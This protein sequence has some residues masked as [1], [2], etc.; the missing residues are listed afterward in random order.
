MSRLIR[1]NWF[2]NKK[3]ISN[4]FNVIY[5]IICQTDTCQIP[6]IGTTKRMMKSHLADQC[7]YVRNL[8]E[9]TA[10]GSH[11]NSPGH[12]LL[13]RRIIALEQ[14]KTKNPIYKNK[15]RHTIL[16][17]L[18]VLQRHLQTKL[19]EEEGEDIVFLC[20]IAVKCI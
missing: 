10:T 11:F 9:N 4:T 14:S 5:A 12:S 2:I 19:K 17:D 20:F 6:Y 7:V 8:R 3:L 13:E 18:N 16:I 1:E 15:G